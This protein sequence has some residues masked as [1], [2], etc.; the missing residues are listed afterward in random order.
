MKLTYQLVIAWGDDYPTLTHSLEALGN[1]CPS[2][3]IRIDQATGSSGGWPEVTVRLDEQ[4]NDGF[5]EWYGGKG[6]TAE[7]LL[8]ASGL[9]PI[10][11]EGHPAIWD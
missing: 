10:R 11:E 9:E 2:A 4:D 5:C 7:S 1:L 3:W 8:A 6:A